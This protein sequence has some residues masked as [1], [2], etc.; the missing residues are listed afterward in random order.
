MNYPLHTGILAIDSMFPIGAS[1]RG[2][3]IGDRQTSKT[4]I[5]GCHPEPEEHRCAV[6][7]CGHRPES[8]FMPVAGDLQAAVRELHHH[9]GGYCFG[10]RSPAVHHYTST[11]TGRVL[12]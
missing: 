6:H 11:R 10:F 8:F 3:I 1:Q 5:A 9:R 7:L 4:S 12:P 2:L